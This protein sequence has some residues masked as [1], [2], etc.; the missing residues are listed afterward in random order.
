MKE[1]LQINLKSIVVVSLCLT[2][3]SYCM[4]V[5]S[6]VT[7]HTNSSDLLKGKTEDTIISSRGTIQLGRAAEEVIKEFE[8]F[9]DVWSINCIV[10]SGG[11]I[12]F[13]TSPNG[14]IYQYSLRK[15]TK[16][17]PNEEQNTS[18]EIPAENQGNNNA[19]EH[20]TNEHIFAMATDIAGRLLVGIS[21][22]KCR[23]CRY[24]AEEFKDVFE[25]NEA[26]YIYAITLDD[27]GNIYLGTGPEGK[28]YRLD[29]FGGKPEIIYSSRDKNILSLAVGPDGYLYAGSDDRG[30]IY[31]INPRDK[32][33]TVLYDSEQPEITALLFMQQITSQTSGNSTDTEFSLYAAATSAQVVQTQ[34]QFAASMPEGPPAGRP[35]TDSD[36]DEGEGE[37][38]NENG[39][40]NGD[41]NNGDNEGTSPS[42]GDGRKLEIANTKEP[43]PARPTQATPPVRR[44]ARPR[45]ASNIYKISNEGFVTN[46][47]GESAI[48]FCLA[49]QGTQLLVGTGNKAQLYSVDPAP[50]E[51]AVIFEDEQ[52][53]Q[54]TAVTAIG[55]DIYL[56]TANPAKLI[57]LEPGFA[58][59]GTYISDL[60]DA[61]Q[62]ARWGK[63]Q[64]EAEIPAGCKVL[65]ASRSGNVK[66]VNDPTFSPWT[67]LVEVTEPVQLECPLGRFCQY[68]LVLQSG[69]GS[70]SPLIREIAV[71][72]T[73]P[74][75]PPKVESVTISQVQTPNKTGTYKINFRTQDDNEDKLVYKIDFRKVGWTNWI[76][77]KDDLEATNFEW[78]GKTLEDGRY[79]IRVTASDEKS[80]TTSTKLTGS[81]VSEPIVIDNTGPVVKEIQTTSTSKDG[82]DL[83]IFK[84][85]VSD[86]FSAIE[87]L[88]YTIDS[89]TNW[90]ATV[91][92]D[93]VYDTKNESFSIAI[94]MEKDLPKGGHILTIKVNDSV[95]N[96]TYKTLEHNVD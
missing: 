75:L 50:E 56:G 44:G 54:I 38:G 65:V 5:T 42:S 61:E 53:V 78:D 96:T 69:N 45:T 2:L 41:E 91:P 37:N 71:A 15:I 48:F 17:Y 85:E 87:K 34:T 1:K 72:S 52:A 14:C 63:L 35:D 20:I 83:T 59:E 82:R 7:R 51:Q 89:N 47:F 92:E 31:K 12:Y 9:A 33:T 25:P 77:L 46:I 95:G 24:E 81:R 49:Q 3:G 27:S 68:K 6:K 66:D 11:T 39:N 40:E 23:L 67:E 16:I 26:K 86:E 28:I 90:I 70:A 8:D 36:E 57:K 62:P 30:L 93:L 19:Q 22:E 94:D 4:G 18:N 80:N 79:E 60:I 88:E 55:D 13:G 76:Q 10:E 43:A 73:I 29:S 32:E 74:N 84:I 64:L 21:G 58:S